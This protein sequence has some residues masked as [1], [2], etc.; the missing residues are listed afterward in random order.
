MVTRFLPELENGE[1]Q[2]FTAEVE[3]FN[4]KIL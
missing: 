4:I 1:R 3:G 2:K